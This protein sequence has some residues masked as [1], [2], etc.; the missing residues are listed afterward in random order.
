MSYNF[1]TQLP[2]LVC[3]NEMAGALTSVGSSVWLMNCT[4]HKELKKCPLNAHNK[5]KM[6]ALSRVL[7]MKCREST[8]N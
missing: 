6:T 1:L 3:S 7:R 2:T 5:Y 8:R 4:Q